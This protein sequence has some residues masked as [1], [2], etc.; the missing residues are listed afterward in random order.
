MKLLCTYFVA[1]SRYN[2]GQET[3]FHRIFKAAQTYPVDIVWAANWIQTEVE[4]LGGNVVFSTFKMIGEPQEVS[5][6]F[7]V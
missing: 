6:D 4:K 7:E 3:T 2:Y 5:D 1:G